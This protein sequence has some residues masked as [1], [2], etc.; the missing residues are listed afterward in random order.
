MAVDILIF[1]NLGFLFFSKAKIGLLKE[2]Q[3]FFAFFLC[4]FA[5]VNKTL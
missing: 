2:K 1:H 3:V 4:G 5:F